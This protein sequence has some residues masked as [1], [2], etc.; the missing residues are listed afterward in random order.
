ML[1]RFIVMFIIGMIYGAV[2]FLYGYNTSKKNF[3]NELTNLIKRLPED[4][5]NEVL[6]L[7]NKD[8]EESKNI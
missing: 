5:Q 4:V 3:A 8:T 7:I 6:A 1:L 2:L